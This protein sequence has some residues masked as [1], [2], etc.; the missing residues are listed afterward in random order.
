MVSD[1]SYRPAAIADIEEIAEYTIE[2]W[3]RNQGRSYVAALRKDIESLT[4]FALRYPLHETSKLNLRRM[5]SGH[6]LVFYLVTDQ[7]VEIIRIL[8]E[9]MDVDDRV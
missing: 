3:G 6:H 4:E 9:R 5:N 1:I 8:H 2:R 7:S